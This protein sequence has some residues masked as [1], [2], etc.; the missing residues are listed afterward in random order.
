[1]D[2]SRVSSFIN[3]IGHKREMENEIERAKRREKNLIQKY[4]HTH[5]RR[6][7]GEPSKTECELDISESVMEIETIRLAQLEMR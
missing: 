6:V 2:A 4:I 1:L 7:S 3:F 5:T